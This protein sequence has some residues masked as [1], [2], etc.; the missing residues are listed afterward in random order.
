MGIFVTA[1]GLSE[2]Y[3]AISLE[4]RGFGQFYFSLHTSL[5]EVA[6]RL[7]F[8]FAFLLNSN[9]LSRQVD[10]LKKRK[11]IFCGSLSFG[12]TL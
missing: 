7:R 12:H 11:N 10:K 2:D 8:F 6:V 3:G 1:F 5:R 4:G 9:K